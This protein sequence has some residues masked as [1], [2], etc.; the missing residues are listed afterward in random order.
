MHGAN[1]P[2][3][4]KEICYSMICITHASAPTPTLVRRRACI[5]S[6]VHGLDLDVCSVC[7]VIYYWGSKGICSTTL[8]ISMT[9]TQVYA[10]SCSFCIF[11]AARI[12]RLAVIF[13]KALRPNA[14]SWDVHTQFVDALKPNKLL[15]CTCQATCCLLRTGRHVQIRHGRPSVANACKAQRAARDLHCTC[16]HA[17][18]P[19]CTVADALHAWR[20]AQS[21]PPWWQG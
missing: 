19:M 7:G 11:E 17:T 16:P 3:N 5:F 14:G 4:P 2:D 20:W 15:V 21:V 1:H 9:H 12:L 13:V 18:I 8:V 6:L 10:R